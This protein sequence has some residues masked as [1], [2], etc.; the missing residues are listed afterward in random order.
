MEPLTDRELAV[1]RLLA[2]TQLSQSE[3]ADELY[4][5]RNTVKS[6]SRSIYRKLRVKSRGRAALRA[7]D[8]GLI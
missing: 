7:Q 6:H 1:L 2:T 3:I 8:L 5:S 4:V